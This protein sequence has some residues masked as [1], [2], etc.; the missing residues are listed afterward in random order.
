MQEYIKTVAKQVWFYHI[1]GPTRPGYA[2][3]ITKL[4][5]VLNTQKQATH[6]N[7]KIEISNPKKFF[8]H[9][10]HLKSGEPLPPWGYLGSPTSM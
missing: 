8:N 1:C 6:K 5:I 4:Q 3:T 2:G 9:P 10:C 7:L